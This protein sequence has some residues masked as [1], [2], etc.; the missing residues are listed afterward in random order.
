MSLH[1]LEATENMYVPDVVV[2]STSNDAA[3]PADPASA[4]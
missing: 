3:P 4:E 2:F 1:E